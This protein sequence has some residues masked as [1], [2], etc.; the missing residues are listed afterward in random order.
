[1]IYMGKNRCFLNTL[2]LFCSLSLPQAG[3][4]LRVEAP[5]WEIDNALELVNRPYLRLH[6]F[7]CLRQS[8]YSAVMKVYGGARQKASRQSR[9]HCH[10][11]SGL[12]VTPA[13]G[14]SRPDVG[15]VA[16]FLEA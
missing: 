13:R 2:H 15:Y 8:P 10:Y 3:V 7:F 5:P 1:M 6:V 9:T 11:Y 14:L 4:P 12:F 16:H